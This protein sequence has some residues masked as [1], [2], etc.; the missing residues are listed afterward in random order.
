MRSTDGQKCTSAL[1]TLRFTQPRLLKNVTA[2]VKG[3]SPGLLSLS[4]DFYLIV[5]LCGCY[6]LQLREVNRVAYEVIR[7][8]SI[9][10]MAILHLT[11]IRR[12]RPSP[13]HATTPTVVPLPP[14]VALS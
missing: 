2:H 11:P 12:Q 14:T 4:A 13:Y 6:V 7:T 3:R 1:R 8:C 10:A 9:L 5:W